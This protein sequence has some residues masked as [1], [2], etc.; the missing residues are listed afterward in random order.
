MLSFP[1]QTVGAGAVQVDGVLDP[2]DKVWLEGDQRPAKAGI[3]VSGRLSTAGDGRYYFTGT[4]AGSVGGE[5]GRCLAEVE[6]QVAAAVHVLFADG[7][8]VDEDDPDVLPLARGRSGADVD[9]RPAVRQE[10]LLEVPAIVLCRPEC[11]GLCAKCGANLNQG[12]CTC[13]RKPTE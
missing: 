3:R 13:A 11:K 9:L 8:H 1:T 2:D 10:W 6:S 5:C 7:S 4:L 12:P